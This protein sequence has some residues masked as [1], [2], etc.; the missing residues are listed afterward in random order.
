MS[1][2]DRRGR[3]LLPSLSF[4]SVFSLFPLYPKSHHSFAVHPCQSSTVTFGRGRDRERRDAMGSHCLPRESARRHRESET[5]NRRRPNPLR[6]PLLSH[7]RHHQ[8]AKFHCVRPLAAAKPRSPAHL[9][10][11]SAL[12][13]PS[14]PGAPPRSRTRSSAAFG[15]P[16]SLGR[17]YIS[18]VGWRCAR[19]ADVYARACKPDA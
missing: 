14:R 19:S 17:T 10:R 1:S 13:R 2:Q 18:A 3:T 5:A 6:R 9:A 8:I 12:L 4:L 15:P 7:D 16:V 11:S